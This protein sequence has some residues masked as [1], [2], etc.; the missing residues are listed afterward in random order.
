VVGEQRLCNRCLSCNNITFARE[1][2]IAGAGI[3]GIPSMIC[4][5]SVESGELLEL[6]PEALLPAG[7]IYAVYPSRRFQAMKVRAFLDFVIQRL[8]S[9]GRDLLEP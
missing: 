2:A 8:P 7:E 5:E 4:R 3:A 9:T 1:A 6:L